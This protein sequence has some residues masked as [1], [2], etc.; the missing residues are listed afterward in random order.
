MPA[1]EP[2]GQGSRSRRQRE[3]SG[4]SP[5]QRA[6]RD[7]ASKSYICALIQEIQ[8]Q[9]P[10]GSCANSACLL[11]QDRLQAGRSSPSLPSAEPVCSCSVAESLQGW[12][13][14]PEP[15]C[16]ACPR[17]CAVFDG[18]FGSM[19]HCPALIALKPG[20]RFCSLERLLLKHV[21]P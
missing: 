8:S 2:E 5:G 10:C 6:L 20:N 14:S 11:A 16:G 18:R 7:A 13:L 9:S 17:H 19:A 1:Q 12:R 15:C 4:E 3:G 21:G